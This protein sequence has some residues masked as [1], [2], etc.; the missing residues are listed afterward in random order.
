[1]QVLPFTLD[2]VFLHTPLDLSFYKLECVFTLGE[3]NSSYE[4]A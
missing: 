1:M 4:N 2:K 3:R